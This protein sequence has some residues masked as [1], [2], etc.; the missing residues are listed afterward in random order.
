MVISYPGSNRGS[1]YDR[2]DYSVT[3]SSVHCVRGKIEV[4]KR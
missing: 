1:L 2:D 3:K 4:S